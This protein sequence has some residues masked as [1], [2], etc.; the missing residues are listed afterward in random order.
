MTNNLPFLD[1][2]DLF[3]DEHLQGTGFTMGVFAC[4]RAGKTY[5]V[6]H[7]Y[8]FTKLKEMPG[9]LYS[10]SYHIDLYKPLRENLAVF[11]DLNEEVIKEMKT[12]NQRCSNYYSFL[13]VIDDEN[14]SKEKAEMK[15][16]FQ[17][18]RNSNLSSIFSTQ[19]FSNMNK[20]SRDQL[21]YVFLGS[22]NLDNTI[23]EVMK[24]FVGS[25][26]DGSMS[27]KIMEY[28]ELTKDHHFL[29]LNNFTGEL[30][31]YKAK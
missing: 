26:F 8:K 6:Q 21:N 11:P 20:K 29:L 15:N 31:R 25:F 2:R 14:M 22:F 30:F 24:M 10:N 13:N 12:I 17:V 28:R 7:L 5:L 23:E 18:Y 1:I 27:D 16:L 9:C 3:K 19:M 4:S